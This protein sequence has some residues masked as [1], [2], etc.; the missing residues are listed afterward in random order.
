MI[1]NKLLRNIHIKNKHS[2]DNSKRSSQQFLTEPKKD[3][4]TNQ[5]S[6]AKD[7]DVCGAG[8]EY[9]DQ[10]HPEHV[11]KQKRLYVVQV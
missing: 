7:A 4:T 1:W 10:C 5:V 2:D 8:Y 3:K 6:H 11:L 9:K